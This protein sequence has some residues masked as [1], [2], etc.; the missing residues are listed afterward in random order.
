M[1]LNLQR[2]TVLALLTLATYMML[3]DG[4]LG[5]IFL[6]MYAPVEV[7]LLA[8]KRPIKTR[9]VR[10]MQGACGPL[11]VFGVAFAVDSLLTLLNLTLLKLH[12]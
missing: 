11:V 10:W 5:I 4:Q 6:G 3:D 2:W 7:L 8:T 12:F 1:R 9:I